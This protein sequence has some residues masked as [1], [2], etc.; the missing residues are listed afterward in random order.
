MYGLMLGGGVLVVVYEHW[1]FTELPLNS[2]LCQG[3]IINLSTM[4]RLG[5]RIPILRLLQ[6]NKY[7]L[8]LSMGLLMRQ[9]RP[10]FDEEELSKETVITC[11]FLRI[12]M[13]AL[14][15]WKGFLRD[16]RNTNAAKKVL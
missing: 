9:I 15:I 3:V 14:G 12:S 5:P 2:F 13:V 6:D 11:Q 16:A 10:I 1:M 8:W 7:L 4:L